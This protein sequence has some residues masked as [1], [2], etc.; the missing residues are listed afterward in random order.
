MARIDAGT[1]NIK[2]IQE[3]RYCFNLTKY[4]PYVLITMTY[5]LKITINIDTLPRLCYNIIR[6]FPIK[7]GKRLAANQ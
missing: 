2:I 7:G 1:E 5:H 6:D 3:N 4:K